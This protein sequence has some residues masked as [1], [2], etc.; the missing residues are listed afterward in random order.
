MIRRPP[1]STLL[2]YPTLFR[3]REK[4]VATQTLVLRRAAQEHE[5]RQ[6]AETS[7]RRERIGRRHQLF[8]EG[9]RVAHR[10]PVRTKVLGVPSSAP[11]GGGRH[12][13]A[14]SILRASSRSLSV[15]PPAEWVF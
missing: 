6:P 7:P 11:P 14:S 1:K 9:E 5:D 10:S 15:T 3:S 13:A 4:R 12:S 2:P 8:D